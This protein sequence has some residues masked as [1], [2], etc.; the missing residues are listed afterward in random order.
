MAGRPVPQGLGSPL[1][2]WLNAG[3]DVWSAITGPFCP[4]C[5]MT[6]SLLW[7]AKHGFLENL[8]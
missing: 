7:Q 1:E 2:I 8:E 5:E 6:A 3:R 4:A